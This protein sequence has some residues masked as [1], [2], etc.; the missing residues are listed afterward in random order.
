[1]ASGGTY[2]LKAGRSWVEVIYVHWFWARTVWLVEG[3]TLKA[4]RSWVE[5]VYVHWFPFYITCDRTVGVALVCVKMSK[6]GGN[7]MERQKTG[8]CLFLWRKACKHSM[9][10]EMR[11]SRRQWPE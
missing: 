5:V 6:C 8:S 2:P 1:M 10:N 4:W 3:R 9:V 7:A 11:I